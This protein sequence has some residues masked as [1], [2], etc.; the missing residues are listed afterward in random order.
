MIQHYKNNQAKIK[1]TNTQGE[2][3]LKTENN[4]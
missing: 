3:S 4:H 2:L 1:Y